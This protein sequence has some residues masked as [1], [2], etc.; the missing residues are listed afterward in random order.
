MKLRDPNKNLVK[1]IERLVGVR[2][3]QPSTGKFYPS[4]QVLF[5]TLPLALS[6]Y[7]VNSHVG[8]SLTINKYTVALWYKPSIILYAETTRS[9][10]YVPKMFD[11]LNKG[12]YSSFFWNQYTQEESNPPLCLALPGANINKFSEAEV[13]FILATR[14]LLS[15]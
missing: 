3:A 12:Y 6:K 10:N 4:L 5:Y 15:E 1:V 13:D 8:Y 11:N 2:L 14:G 9:Q 7:P